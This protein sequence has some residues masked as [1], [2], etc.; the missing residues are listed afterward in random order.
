[1]K[2]ILL[3]DVE[4]LGKR[5]DTVEVKGG[6]GLNYLIPQKMAIVANKANSAI[7]GERLRQ[8]NRKVESERQAIESLIERVKSQPITVGAKV[9]TT[10]KIFGSVTNVQLSDAIKRQTGV[11]LDR[12]KISIPDE[13]KVLGTYTAVID[14]SDGNK[15]EIEFEVVPE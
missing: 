15:Q 11:E 6:Y 13:V 2:I 7:I 1:M 10:D 8:I 5:F 4:N 12:R 14:F 9:G 3:K